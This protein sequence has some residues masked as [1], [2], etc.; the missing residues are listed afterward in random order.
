MPFHTNS[1]AKKM[2]K[3]SPKKRTGGA[4]GAG[5]KKP[6]KTTS[7]M[8][9]DR[10]D[11]LALNPGFGMREGTGRLTNFQKDFMKVHEKQHSKAHNDMMIKLMKEGACP[12]RAHMETMK[13]VGK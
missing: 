8:R 4:G 1:D 10:K 5:R 12:E 9:S 13:K 11:D 6:A 2:E 3:N 7:G